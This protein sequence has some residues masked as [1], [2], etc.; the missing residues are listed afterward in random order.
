MKEVLP[1]SDGVME[2]RVQESNANMVESTAGISGSANGVVPSLQVHLQSQHT[3]DVDRLAKSWHKGV[4][5]EPC[6]SLATSND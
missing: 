3:I 5:D 6:E 4:A 2:Y 1:T